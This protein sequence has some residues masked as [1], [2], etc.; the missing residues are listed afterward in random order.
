MYLNVVIRM[1][2]KRNDEKRYFIAETSLLTLHCLSKGTYR[3]ELE[4]VCMTKA[5]RFGLIHAVRGRYLQCHSG[6]STIAGNESI[7]EFRLTPLSRTGPRVNGVDDFQDISP[8]MGVVRRRTTLSG[9]NAIS[10]YH[11][12]ASKTDSRPSNWLC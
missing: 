9:Y 4:T 3:T 1:I 6:Q 12:N 7:F 8:M 11:L 10:E 2:I 5:T